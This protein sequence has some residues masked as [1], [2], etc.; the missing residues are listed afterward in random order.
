M[1]DI[2]YN[3]VIRKLV[4]GFGS[5]FDKI[6]L[7]RYNTDRSEQ[8]RLLVPLTYATKELYVRRL[9]DDP[10]LQKKIQVALPRMSFEMNGLTY[11]VT[12][13]QNTNIKQFA[14]TTEGVVSQYNPVPYNFDFSLYIYVRN[15]EDGTQ[16][17]EHIL[18][19]FTPDYT[20]KLNLIPEMGI[21]KEV[22]V[23]L[24][25][26]THEIVYEGDK[27]S[28]TRMIIWTLNFTVKGFIFGKISD[29][30]GL[31]NH[32]ITNILTNITPEDTVIL[33]MGNVAA[34]G[35]GTYKTDEIVYQGYSSSSATASGKVVDWE[36]NK[37]YIKEI[38]GHFV[39]NKPVVGV[40]S[41]ASYNFSSYQVMPKRM[42]KIDVFA[43][44]TMDN[45]LDP[46]MDQNG[47]TIDNNHKITTIITE[48]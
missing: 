34:I 12:R 7:V 17:I 10:N 9:E 2:T 40:L 44:L 15:M 13:K 8:Q 21:V 45:D 41:G 25:N 3:R 35:T 24:N 19:Y 43:D 4:V 37:L 26:A 42:S 5:L 47:A 11:D 22:P 46:L 33:N 39:S 30:G 32:S 29:V 48:S 27:N 38:N 16:I 23:I 18:P 1:S 28:E 31:I 6:T 20:I 36:N 14:R